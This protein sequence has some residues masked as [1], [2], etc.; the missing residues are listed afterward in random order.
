MLTLTMLINLQDR[1]DPL[2]KSLQVPGIAT[3]GEVERMKRHGEYAEQWIIE[4]TAQ[5]LGRD[6]H[7]VNSC[8]KAG[9][10]LNKIECLTPGE[11]PPLLLGHLADGEHYLSLGWYG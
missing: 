1:T 7:I 10:K 9:S 6:I 4:C 8:A 3:P 11:K 5:M 2:V